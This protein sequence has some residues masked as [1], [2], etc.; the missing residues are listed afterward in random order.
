L[1]AQPRE[2]DA[3][4]GPFQAWGR[5]KRQLD[6]KLASTVAPWRLHDLRRTVSTVMHDRLEVAPHIVEAVLGH[7]SAHRTGVAGIY[8][9]AAYADQKRIALDKWAEL[10][11]TIVSGK[12]PAT[13]VRLRKAK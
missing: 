11:M 8:N 9:R 3:V 4:F 7:Y 10:L 2:R 6:C 13:V 12:K 1:K 5:R